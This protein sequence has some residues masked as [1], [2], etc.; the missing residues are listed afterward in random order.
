MYTQRALE[1]AW[2][3]LGM[4]KRKLMLSWDGMDKEKGWR[5]YGTKRGGLVPRGHIVFASPHQPGP[6]NLS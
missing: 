6:C 4:C 3:K 1:E 2:R 5:E